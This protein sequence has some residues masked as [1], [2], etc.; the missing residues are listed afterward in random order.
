MKYGINLSY[1][2]NT[3]FSNAAR[4]V[5]QAGFTH[6]DYTPPVNKDD[7]Q[8][9]MKDVCRVLSEYGLTVHQTHIPFNRYGGCGKN[10]RLYVERCLEA[11]AF[12]GAKYTAVHG[13]EFDFDNMEYSPK[14]AFDYNHNYFKK[15]VEFAEKAGFKLAFETVFEDMPLKKRFTSSPDDLLALI[16]SFNSDSAVCCWDFGHANVSF[17]K[18][19]PQQITE[20]GSL[21][22][23]TH[24]HDNAG[25]DSHQM[26][27][28]GDIDWKL[29]MGA[30][31]SAGFDGVLSIEYAHGNIPEHMI[32]RYIQLT[33]DAVSHI[34]GL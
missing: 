11:T 34:A 21:I 24:V 15:D 4:L 23:C 7:W 1:F 16:K 30:L 6:V 17:R 13:D 31:K 32:E 8:T 20:F 22:Q 25:N 9:I 3:E 27:L 19:A 12:M 26:P 18:T 10:H 2:R 5:S 29:T 28:T 14:A 33:Y